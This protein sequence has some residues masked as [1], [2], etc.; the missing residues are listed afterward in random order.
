M[1]IHDLVTLYPFEGAVN[2]ASLIIAEK[3]CKTEFPVHCVMWHNPRSKGIGQEAELEEI[4]K[5]QDSSIW[6]S[7][8]SKR[9]SL[10]VPR[11]KLLKELTKG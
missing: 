3:S 2:R 6:L 7:S 4:K 5:R 1:W 11:W 9:I 8:Q 10:K